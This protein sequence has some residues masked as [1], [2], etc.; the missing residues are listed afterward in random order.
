VLVESK[1]SFYHCWTTSH[2]LL[3]FSILVHNKYIFHDQKVY[4]LLIWAT[5]HKNH[6]VAQYFIKYNICLIKLTKKIDDRIISRILFLFLTQRRYF[7]LLNQVFSSFFST[8][9]STE[10]TNPNNT[11]EPEIEHQPS[12]MAFSTTRS[13]VSSSQ[14]LLNIFI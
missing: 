10:I 12:S 6:K 3:S 13:V 7:L 1:K 9:G 4:M 14:S 11:S 2:K 5:N 8:I